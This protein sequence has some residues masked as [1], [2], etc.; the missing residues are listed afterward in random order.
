MKKVRRCILLVCLLP[1]IVFPI[2][3]PAQQ[4]ITGKTPSLKE[5]FKDDFVIGTALNRTQIEERDPLAAGFIPRQFS[6]FTPENDMKA[7]MIHPQWGTYNFSEADKI[8]A[9]S[10]KHHMRINGHTLIWHS[11]L[12]VFVRRMQDKDSL[13]RFFVEHIST[14]A[15]RYKGK[16]YSWDVVNEA[17]N[18]DGTMRNSIFR[19]KLGED[20]VVEA[21]KLAQQAAPG[22]MLYY[23]DYNIER[24]EKRAGAITLVKKIQ[25]AGVRIDGIGIQGHW[26]IDQVPLKDIEQSILEFSSLGV[27]VMFTELDISVLPDPIGSNGA[28]IS[29]NTAYNAALNPYVNGLPDS[30]QSKLAGSYEDLFRLFLKY[31]NKISRI[32]FWGVND[33][34]SWLNNWPV[35]GRTNYPLLFD[36]HFNPKPAFYKVIAT[37]T[38]NTDRT[39]SH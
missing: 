22:T 19:E 27:K 23:N 17:L 5:V 10:Q 39:A 6:A 32:T 28:D 33:G 16:V 35:R 4:A 2:R 11:Q 3:L 31:K 8:I 14:I 34:N 20:Y 29:Q 36:R 21:F 7:V 12:P 25:A 15:S 26:H 38:R 30:L 37:K 9:Y 24:P 18:E 13:H 1:V